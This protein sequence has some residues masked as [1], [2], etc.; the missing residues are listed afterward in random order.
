M[1]KASIANSY[2]LLFVIPTCLLLALLSD[3]S[4]S[5]WTARADQ[6]L[7]RENLLAAM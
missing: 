3:Y 7:S 1:S 2:H 4:F 5:P 6:P